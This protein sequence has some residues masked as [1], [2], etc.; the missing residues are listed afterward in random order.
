M[1]TGSATT[2]IALGSVA[3][4]VGLGL[5]ALVGL[6]QLFHLCLGKVLPSPKLGVRPT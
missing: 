4:V 5:L 2:G 3:I 1:A 6:D